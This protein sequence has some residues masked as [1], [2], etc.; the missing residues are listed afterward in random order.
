MSPQQTSRALPTSSHVKYPPIFDNALKTYEEK[1]GKVLSSDPLLHK[2]EMC[3]STDLII[4]IL[5]QQIPRIDQPLSGED[6]LQRWLKPIVDVIS[7]F[8]MAMS[9]TVGL[10]SH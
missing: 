4:T 1:T 8:S 9:W 10:V 6:G 5:R 2:L 7:S 3:D